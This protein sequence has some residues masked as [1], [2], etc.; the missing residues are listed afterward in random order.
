MCNIYSWI[1]KQ[2]NTL[3]LNKRSLSLIQQLLNNNFNDANLKLY[4][5]SSKKAPEKRFMWNIR[6]VW[7]LFAT[8]ISINSIPFLTLLENPL[9]FK[10]GFLIGMNE[11]QQTQ[12]LK[13][14][15]TFM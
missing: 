14:P 6:L 9:H 10:N 8:I 12:F 1:A 2:S 3:N 13:S 11:T 15:L 4:K 5:S 7:H